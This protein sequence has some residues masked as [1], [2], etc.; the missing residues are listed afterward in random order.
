MTRYTRRAL[1]AAGGTLAAATLPGKL[2]AEEELQ[3]FAE[4]FKAA[5]PPKSQAALAF[6]TDDGTPRT[7]ADYAGKGLVLN[8]WATWCV[9]CVTEMPALD[10][11]A[12]MLAAS[13]ILVLPLSSDRGGA[14]V[15]KSYYQSHGIGDLPVILD[16]KGATARALAV[17]GIPTTLII[18]RKGNE[19][20]RMEGAVAWS[21]DASLKAIKK[22]IG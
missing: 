8:L 5:S 19:L 13:K 17:R 15:V 18:D 1:L 22:L 6:T 20:G 10:Q 16:P 12:R 7:V 21:S 4:A 11:A 14:S 3:S 9:P 2:H